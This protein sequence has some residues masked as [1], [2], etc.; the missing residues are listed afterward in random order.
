LTWKIGE[1]PPHQ[2]HR[3]EYQ[4]IAKETGTFRN[5]AKV[6]ATGT[7]ATDKAAVTVGKSKLKISISGPQRR[8]VNRPI[9]YHITVGNIGTV[10]LTNVLVSNELPP[11]GFEFQSASPGG[12]REGGFMRW[13]LGS[14]KP[15]EVR[16]LLL[17]LHSTK[18]GWV[19][20]EVKV[21]ADPNLSDK[22]QSVGTHIDKSA[23]TPVIE[24]DKS[25]DSLVVGQKATYTIRLLNPGKNNV[26]HPSVHVEVPEAMSIR[27]QRGPTTGQQLGQVVRFAPLGA[28]DSGQEQT[29]FVEV[30]ARKAGE[31]R[32]RAWWTDGRQE[33][34]PTETW[35][36]KTTILD[37]A[38][39][40]SGRTAGVSRLVKAP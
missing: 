34:S 1:I 8:L 15:G 39:V 40:V 11:G 27:G 37:P 7:T 28:L 29:Y 16:S 26:L 23:G 17:V 12:Q 13:A 20:D 5:N 33:S 3:I 18:P 25:S 36:D 30:E 19:W 10:P 4:A 35:E 31:A 14:L 22:A 6:T 32:L 21:Q 2:T 24:I 9:P 38:K